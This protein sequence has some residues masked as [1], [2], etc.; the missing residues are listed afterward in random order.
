MP[1]ILLVED[2]LMNRDMLSRRLERRGFAVLTA[3]D[4]VEGV[5]VAKRE[6]PDVILM[7]MSL[8]VMDGYEATRLLKGDQEAKAIP[9]LGLSAHAMA[10]DADKARA[11]GCDDYDTKPVDFKR[12]LEKIDALLARTEGFALTAPEAAPAAVPLGGS[13]L[14]GCDQ[15]LLRDAVAGRL[16]SLG[17]TVRM[18]EERHELAATLATGGHDAI[19]VPPAWLA[20]VE[21]Q[22][23]PVPVLAL[24]ENDSAE[25][26]LQA[27]KRGARDVL[28]APFSP[29]LLR[30]RLGAVLQVG[31]AKRRARQLEDALGDARGRAEGLLRAL[32]PPFAVDELTRTRRVE[33]HLH[34]DA[35][36]LFVDLLGFAARSVELGPT[37]ALA[38]LQRW[39]V[40][41]EEVATRHGVQKLK[42][43]GDEFIAVVGLDGSPGGD[44]ARTA[45]ACALDLLA[46]ARD[47][48]DGLPARAG[49]QVGP[50][51]TGV[52]GRSS[53][54]FDAWGETI[55]SASRLEA[56]A[57]S[58][59]LYTSSEVWQRV[60]PAR[61]ALVGRLPRH[62]G[63]PIDV[64]RIDALD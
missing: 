11:A 46:I 18:I 48:P 26:T 43:S 4:G 9:I 5:Q 53:F 33:P 56:V 63:Q 6:R 29:E 36:V 28:P 10:G 31:A 21:L 49:V 2:N 54:L 7:D 1:K 59:A 25:A 15:V 61:G 20:A 34:S 58:G 30:S 52:V 3:G 32:L 19:L 23:S 42:T 13:V 14:V 45:V 55:E 38:L 44:R 16:R 8:P 57:S 64:Y 24:L 12:L 27:L 40:A 22:T 37:A 62:V 39:F 17:V 50:L 47:T 51:L 41:C 35:A 60:Q